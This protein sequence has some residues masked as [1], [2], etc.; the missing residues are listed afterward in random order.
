[1]TYP[2]ASLSDP[3]NMMGN[4]GQVNSS[5]SDPYNMGSSGIGSGASSA[6]ALA[7]MGGLPGIGTALAI[8]GQLYSLFDQSKA[9]KEARKAQ[10][11]QQ[12]QE[13][14][15]NLLRIVGG[16]MPQSPSP[17][18]P[19]PQVQVASSAAGI[20]GAL[21]SLGQYNEQK[22]RAAAQAK[23]E[24]S[25][26][27]LEKLRALTDMEYKDALAKKA[28][29]EKGPT[30]S[31]QLAALKARGDIKSMDLFDTKMWERQN[32][33][34]TAPPAQISPLGMQ[35]LNSVLQEAGFDIN[36]AN[37][38]SSLPSTLG[39]VTVKWNQ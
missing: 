13:A 17:V 8:G 21:S 26:L 11:K 2:N 23:M 20:G 36:P 4:Y 28:A 38:S 35:Y 16:G 25:R 18:Q 37:S 24:E 3:Y 30:R 9:R 14:F 12:Q 19:L 1:M 29:K 31:E 32:P 27:A 6:G 7:A 22:Q 33:G 5:L 10:Q 34:K 15:T 39:G